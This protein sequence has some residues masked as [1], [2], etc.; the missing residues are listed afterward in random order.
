VVTVVLVW[1]RPDL[2]HWFVLP[3]TGCAMLIGPDAVAWFRGR[4]DVFHPQGLIGVLGLHFFY[5]AP[6]LH[7]LLGYWA[8]EL[9]PPADWRHA[10]GVMGCLNLAGLVVYR[11][12]LRV[13]HAERPVRPATLVFDEYRFRRAALVA[14]AVAAAAFVAELVVLGGVS[15]YLSVMTEVGPRLAGMGWLLVVAESFPALVLLYVVVRWRPVLAR[16]PVPLVLCLV[17][18]ALVQFLVAGLRGS[19]SNTVWP[20]LIA[21]I[22]VHL[23][24]RPVT[25]RALV[26]FALTVMLFMYAYGFYKDAG[27][28]MVDVARGT[29]TVQEISRQTGRDWAG[30]LLGDLGR[31][32]VQALVLD[33]RL[34][35]AGEPG[36]GS[37]YLAAVSQLV[38]HWI[39]PPQRRPT[40]KLRLGTDLLYGPGVYDAQSRH[41]AQRVYGLTGEAVL[42]V[43]PVGAVLAFLPLGLLVRWWRVRYRRVTDN[44]DLAWALLAPPLVLGTVNLLFSDLDNVVFFLVQRFAPAAVVVLVSL[45]AVRPPRLT[46]PRH[47]ASGTWP[48][49][50]G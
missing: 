39:L 31:A 48:R 21:L 37:T 47:A 22:L 11:L 43:G 40:D 26:P 10:L 24:V 29:R 32:D 30:L 35:G 36:Y 6:L 25:R 14:S 1:A 3:V 16:R 46:P 2:T 18:F 44:R 27:L 20:V 15:G 12:V 41:W 19:R 28:E 50:P 9:A 33:R 13:P 17:G 49:R 42:N 8:P 4:L 38:P 7:V 45:V 34:S 23:V 5:L